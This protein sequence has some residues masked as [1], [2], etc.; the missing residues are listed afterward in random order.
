LEDAIFSY[1]KVGL[2]L[3]L[4]I[5]FTSFSITIIVYWLVSLFSLYFMYWLK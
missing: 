2:T 1:N 4:I 5:I 3:R